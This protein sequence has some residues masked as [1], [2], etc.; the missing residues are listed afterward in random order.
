DPHRALWMIQPDQCCHIRKIEPLQRA[1]LGFDAWI[2]GRKRYQSGQR[3]GLAVFEPDGAR[4]KINPL[5]NW[6]G[7]ALKAH[8]AAHDLPAHPLVAKGYPSIGCGPCTSK[9]EPGEDERSGRWRGQAKE[10]C[11]IH[12]DLEADG[13]GI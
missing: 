1:L 2:T 11:G 13:S 6:S 3:A 4:I 7:E 9:V 5:A 10:E 12:I 8:M